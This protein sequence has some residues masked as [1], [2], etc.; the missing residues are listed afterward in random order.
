MFNLVAGE[1]A[2]DLNI[3]VTIVTSGKSIL[4]GT[5]FTQHVID[6]AT[7]QLTAL[8]VTFEFDERL[9]FDSSFK[10]YS[11]EPLSLKGVSG[12]TYE[13]DVVFKV[14]GNGV[15][16]SSFMESFI[17]EAGVAK[18]EVLTEKGEIKVLPTG[19]LA[20]APHIFSCG[21][22]SDLD[23]QKTFV[24]VENQVNIVAANVTSL[25]AGFTKFKQ[26]KKAS[27]VIGIV[28]LGR[29]GGVC[30][31]GGI[32]LTGGRVAA[33]IKSADLFTKKYH[34]EVSAKID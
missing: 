31:F 3:P 5:G 25:A 18:N 17:T 24:V 14:T 12:K 4:H 30:Q 10:D 1:I 13:A 7:A 27:S 15:G 8:G 19:Q 21:D 9:I 26:Y 11:L 22:V 32:T 20:T 2:T 28:S 29:K 33:M 16:N 6:K 23:P 34:G